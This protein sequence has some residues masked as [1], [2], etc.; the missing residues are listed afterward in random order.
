MEINS[1]KN[2]FASLTAGKTAVESTKIRA[3]EERF[4]ELLEKMQG[5]ERA[6]TAPSGRLNGDWTTGFAHTYTSEADKHALARGAAANQAGAGGEKRTIDRTSKLYESSLELESYLVKQMLNEM[7]KTVIKADG[8]Q[9]QAK[10]IYEDMLYDEYAI[11][12]T[13]GAG[14][15]LADQIYLQLSN[16]GKNNS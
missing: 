16:E 15:G 13:K 11:S 5:E 2:G 3:G 12:M 6:K 9:S 4:S 10:K 8:E 14:F 1:I 7:R